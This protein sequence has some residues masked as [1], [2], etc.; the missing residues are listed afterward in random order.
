MSVN[1]LEAEPKMNKVTGLPAMDEEEKNSG[2]KKVI[3]GLIAVS[4]L[5]IGIGLG[6]VCAIHFLGS[7]D[8]YVTRILELQKYDL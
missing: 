6:I 2:Q 5:N 4:I 3:I 7:K 8:L 1:D